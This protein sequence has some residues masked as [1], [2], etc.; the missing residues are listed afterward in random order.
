MHH[1]CTDARA[2]CTILL[3]LEREEGR[4]FHILSTLELKR[5]GN[6]VNRGGKMS[7]GPVIVLNCKRPHKEFCIYREMVAVTVKKVD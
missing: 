7:D 4:I 6:S 5:P 1:G 3:N 2:L